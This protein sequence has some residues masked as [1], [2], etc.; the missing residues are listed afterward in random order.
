MYIFIH[1]FFS[2]HKV[3]TL[4][5]LVEYSALC[6]CA[7][8]LGGSCDGLEAGAS[9]HETWGPRCLWGRCCGSSLENHV[10]VTVGS[11]CIPTPLPCR[12]LSLACLQ[13]HWSLTLPLYSHVT[14]GAA[15][16]MQCQW[17]LGQGPQQEGPWG[18]V[19]TPRHSWACGAPEWRQSFKL[20]TC[21][22]H[23]PM[24]SKS[25]SICQTL[26]SHNLN[27]HWGRSR[28]S[29]LWWERAESKDR[30][31]EG[32]A[33]TEMRENQSQSFHC[34]MSLYA[35]KFSSSGLF[36]TTQKTIHPEEEKQVLYHK[37]PDSHLCRGGNS[38]CRCWR[39]GCRR[40][41]DSAGLRPGT[42]HRLCGW[43]CVDRSWDRCAWGDFW[44]WRLCPFNP[45]LQTSN[46]T[47][48]KI[49]KPSCCHF[50]DTLQSMYKIL[51]GLRM[52]V[53]KSYLGAEEPS[54]CVADFGAGRAGL[55]TVTASSG[56]G[57]WP[58]AGVTVASLLACSVYKIKKAFML[59]FSSLQLFSQS[60][61]PETFANCYTPSKKLTGYSYLVPVQTAYNIGHSVFQH[62]LSLCADHTA[63]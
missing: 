34:L 36:C 3:F 27:H 10:P 37:E 2:I 33:Q 26:R 62:W 8:S 53:I 24:T 15:G 40:C 4:A 30:K 56:T 46:N 11:P 14:R 52:V 60:S 48:K 28:C 43:R 18:A 5:I 32:D 57:T 39:A 23:G 54:G 16:Q 7:C 29:G 50:S 1:L 25:W 44:S 35:Q 58:E 45:L 38:G 6:Q 13:D 41:G 63:G 21:M 55:E 17:K 49:F 59:K 42:R 12:G 9:V 20:F 19:G 31:I 61:I 51:I 22:I 47:V